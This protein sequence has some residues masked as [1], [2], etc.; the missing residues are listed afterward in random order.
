MGSVTGPIFISMLRYSVFSK[1]S[2]LYALF[3]AYINP[4]TVFLYK[5]THLV[6]FKFWYVENNCDISERE[7]KAVKFET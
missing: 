1:A 4:H 6:L 5:E 3:A 7:S 2:G